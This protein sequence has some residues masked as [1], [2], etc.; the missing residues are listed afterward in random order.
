MTGP[1]SQ[2]PLVASSTRKA[3]TAGAVAGTPRLNS[4]GAYNLFQICP[5]AY[6][7]SQIIRAI[8]PGVLIFFQ[9]LGQADGALGAADRTSVGGGE[10]SIRPRPP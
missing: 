4:Y 2:Q 10:V 5:A 1:S 7:G 6:G 8:S 3:P 9:R